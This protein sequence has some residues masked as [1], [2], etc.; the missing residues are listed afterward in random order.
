MVGVANLIL[1][2]KVQG[3]EASTNEARAAMVGAIADI[4]T[5]ASVQTTQSAA[6]DMSAQ[7]LSQRIT[8]L[9]ARPGCP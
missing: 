6:A 7:A 8:A 9:A 2:R 4:E 1:R 3:A 5:R